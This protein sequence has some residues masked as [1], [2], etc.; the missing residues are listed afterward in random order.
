M[1]DLTRNR[2]QRL[3][4]LAALL[5]SG[6]L[7]LWQGLVWFD[8]TRYDDRR[9]DAVSV[10]EAQVLDLTTMDSSTVE[11]SLDRMGERLSG[12]FKRQ[13]EGFTEAFA[14]AVTKDKVKATGEITGAAV[15]EY[16]DGESASVIVASTAQVAS[17]GK[18]PVERHW[19]FKVLLDRD[20]DQW[21]ISGMEFVQ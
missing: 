2:A 20:D 11:K 3:A 6:A 15:S 16:D 8:D 1:I 5:L 13:F 12:D 4:L 10:A 7:L 17:G 21:L 18:E 14:G 19:R 9:D